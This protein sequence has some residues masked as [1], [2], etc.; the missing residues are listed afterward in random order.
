VSMPENEYPVSLSRE[1]SVSRIPNVLC[2]REYFATEISGDCDWSG[3]SYFVMSS[4]RGEMVPWP[5]GKTVFFSL[6]TKCNPNGDVLR[7]FDF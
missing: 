5:R 1:E 4:L 2:C 6:H 3:I 7:P